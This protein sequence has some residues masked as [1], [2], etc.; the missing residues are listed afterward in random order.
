MITLATLAN[1]TAQQV[2]DQVVAH[3]RSQKVQCV[4]STGCR[5]RYGKLRCAAGCLISDEEYSTKMENNTWKG[6]FFAGLVPNSHI[7]LIRDLQRVHDNYA[8]KH[9][10]NSLN[11]VADKHKLKYTPPN[12]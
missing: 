2:F 8:A 3:L 1:A 11:L 4:G 9:W 5:Y 7:I 6:L 12:Q 10:E